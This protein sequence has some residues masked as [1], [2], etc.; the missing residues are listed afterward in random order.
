MGCVSGA[1]F[2]APVA[3]DSDALAGMVLTLCRDAACTTGAIVETRPCASCPPRLA[4]RLS[5]PLDVSADLLPAGDQLASDGG[6]TV[7]SS[8]TLVVTFNAK[9]DAARDA[10]ANGDVYVVRLAPARGGAAVIDVTKSVTYAKVQPNGAD[11]DG[12]F[13][14][15]SASL[16]GG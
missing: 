3:S 5:G 12:A 9:T 4:V 10:L 7:I 6:T 13:Y 8:Y 11:C 1:T 15:R 2:S 14:C 16:N